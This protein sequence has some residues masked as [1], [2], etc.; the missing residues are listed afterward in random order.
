[1]FWEGCEG[2]WTFRG[3]SQFCCERVRARDFVNAIAMVVSSLSLI[4]LIADRNSDLLRSQVADAAEVHRLTINVI[5]P[6]SD[7]CDYVVMKHSESA[8]VPRRGLWLCSF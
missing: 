3:V 1:M 4:I 2:V 7:S 6:L 8:C 5:T